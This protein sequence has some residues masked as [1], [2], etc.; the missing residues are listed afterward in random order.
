A[1]DAAPAPRFLSRRP[2]TPPPGG[3]RRA[4]G[5]REPG[6]LRTPVPLRAS[7]HSG[8]GVAG[9]SAG[10]E[11]RLWGTAPASPPYGQARL[12]LPAPGNMGWEAAPA[13]CMGLRIYQPTRRRAA[14]SRTSTCQLLWLSLVDRPGLLC[15]ARP[16]WP[17]DRRPPREA[18]GRR[19][20][21]QRTADAP[22]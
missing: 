14:G 16:R 10:G 9:R 19:S 17:G 11:L 15:R 22:R 2:G 8:D 6:G 4:K 13:A 1:Q 18:P 7:R 20:D 12:S 5:G 21:W 3:T